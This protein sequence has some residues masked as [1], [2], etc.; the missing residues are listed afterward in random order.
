VA[1]RSGSA[2]I[3]LPAAAVETRGPTTAVPD[4]E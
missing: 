2:V 4:H 3:A 1:Q